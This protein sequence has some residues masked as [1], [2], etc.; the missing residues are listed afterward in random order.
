MGTVS[1]KNIQRF[2]YD[3][4]VV[5]LLYERY[6]PVPDTYAAMV[7][8]DLEAKEAKYDHDLRSTIESFDYNKLSSV[9]MIGKDITGTVSSPVWSRFSLLEPYYCDF[10]FSFSIVSSYV[11]G[12]LVDSFLERHWNDISIDIRFLRVIPYFYSRL[13]WIWE[14]YCHK[15]I[16]NMAQIDVIDF[17]TGEAITLKGLPIN[18]VIRVKGPTLPSHAGAGYHMPVVRG[19]A[20]FDAFSITETGEVVTFQ[21]TSGAYLRDDNYWGEDEHY[22]AAQY[23][24]ITKKLDSI[25]V[26]LGKESDLLPW[27][28]SG[29]WH[30]VLVVPEI[31][32]ELEDLVA[33][34]QVHDSGNRKWASHVKQYVAELKMEK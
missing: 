26:A 1:S 12:M 5:S 30:H 9:M 16:P 27:K 4:A 13:G 21:Y 25:V 3:E 17:E 2:P 15:K 11:L 7:G 31:E 23:H 8:R 18:N 32:V 10:S 33:T 19:L 24:Y 14:G 34:L 29:T 28:A 6:G 22:K 20:T